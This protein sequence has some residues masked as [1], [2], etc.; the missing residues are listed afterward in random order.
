MCYTASFTTRKL[1]STREGHGDTH[2]PTYLGENLAKWSTRIILTRMTQRPNEPNQPVQVWMSQ[3]IFVNH[4][5]IT[6]FY[7]LGVVCLNV[8]MLSI[9]L[10]L[11]RMIWHKSKPKFT[12]LLTW[13]TV[14]HFSIYRSQSE[15]FISLIGKKN[16]G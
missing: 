11:N 2:E 6:T 16:L 4:S 8:K 1:E 12:H 7:Y 13:R 5:Y 15:P 3:N 10:N 14:V 9:I